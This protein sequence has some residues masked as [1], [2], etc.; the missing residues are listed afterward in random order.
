MPW[1]RRENTTNSNSHD[2]THRNSRILVRHR[3]LRAPDRRNPV[4]HL[5]KEETMNS[6]TIP[7]NATGDGLEPL[8][9]VGLRDHHRTADTARKPVL[10]PARAI[11]ERYG[12][13]QRKVT[14]ANKS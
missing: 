13:I 14:N 7:P 1:M 6:I 2:D 3:S 9:S 12:A 11:G 10:E 5:E 8:G 4:V